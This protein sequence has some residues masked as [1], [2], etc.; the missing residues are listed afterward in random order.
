MNYHVRPS[1]ISGSPDKPAENALPTP[2][3]FWT[4]KE[5]SEDPILIALVPGKWLLPECHEAKCS[6]WLQ[7]ESKE[8]ECDEDVNSSE[9]QIVFENMKRI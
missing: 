1:Y 5:V 6:K 2:A 7:P 8:I 4:P 3:A 9:L